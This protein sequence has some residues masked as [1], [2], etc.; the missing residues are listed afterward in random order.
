MPSSAGGPAERRVAEGRLSAEAVRKLGGILQTVEQSKIFR[1]FFDLE[2]S[3]A[4]LK[5]TKQ[6][7]VK[8]RGSFHTASVDL[9]R[10]A[11]RWRTLVFARLRCSTS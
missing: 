4:S 5:R 10:S 1:D 8:T 9:T 7:R 6:V 2:G 3:K 11:N